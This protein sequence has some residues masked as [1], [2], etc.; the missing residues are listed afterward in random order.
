MHDWV[1]VATVIRIA[2]RNEGFVLRCKADSLLYIAPGMTLA[3]VPPQL[4][5]PRQATV[6][7]VSQLSDTDLV[8][9]FVQDECKQ[10][11][12]KLKGLSVLVS[13]DDLPEEYWDEPTDVFDWLVVDERFGELGRVSDIW[14]NPAQN[15]LV[16]TNSEGREVLIPYVDAFVVD[17]DEDSQTLRV[18]I[19]QG[20]LTLGNE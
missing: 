20:L 4:D 13:A 1:N 12:D 16:V 10:C 14:E 5:C 7:S 6:K 19:P 2:S 17:Q 9:T 3:F 8:V 15:T 18:S 11:A